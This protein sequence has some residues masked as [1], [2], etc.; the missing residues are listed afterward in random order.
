MIFTNAGDMLVNVVPKDDGVTRILVHGCNCQGAM[1]SGIA[2]AI[3][4][5]YPEVFDVYHRTSLTGG[6]KLGSCTRV[7][8]GSE[9]FQ[10]W[11]A[12]T[13]L[14]YA[15]FEH[16]DGSVEPKERRHVSYDAITACFE[17]INYA[18]AQYQQ[19]EVH[20]PLIGCGL[21]NGNWNIVQHIID[22]TLSDNVSKVLWIL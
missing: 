5:K 21:A 3:R 17:N 8:I 15:N 19:V 12:C 4:K 7:F 13:Q 14:F 10:I 6:L 2:K 20:F 22:N 9:K 11:N 1:N 16:A 18:V